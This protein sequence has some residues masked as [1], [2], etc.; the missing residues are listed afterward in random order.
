VLIILPTGAVSGA[1]WTLLVVALGGVQCV[2]PLCYSIV[3]LLEVYKLVVEVIKKV[4][5]II[6]AILRD[7]E[8]LL[9]FGHHCPG[10]VCFR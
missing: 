6:D 3:A 4:K 7:G 10:T 5:S 8:V 2:G 1:E 9:N